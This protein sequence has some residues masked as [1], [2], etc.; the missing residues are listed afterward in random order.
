MSVESNLTFSGTVLNTTYLEV[1]HNLG[2]AGSSAFIKQIIGYADS[3]ITPAAL[4]FYKARGNE[5]S[6]ATVAANDFLGTQRYLGYDGNSYELSSAIRG[7]VD[8]SVS[9]GN[10]PGM[11]NF[12]TAPSGTLQSRMVIDSGGSVGIGTW[13]T[14]SKPHN[15]LSVDGTIGLEE[16]ASADTDAATYGQLWVKS[17]DPNELMFTDGDGKDIA[18]SNQVRYVS[19]NYSN[20]MSSV[21]SWYAGYFLNMGTSISASDWT[22]FHSYLSSIMVAT[23]PCQVKQITISCSA[24][25]TEPYEIE[26]WDVTIPADGASAPSTAAKIGDTIQVNSG[27]DMTVNRLYNVVHPCNHD[28]AAG[29]SMHIATRYTD[30]SGTKNFYYWLT[31]EIVETS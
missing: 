25:S 30:G 14:T 11:L 1:G 17:T 23:T 24:S 9:N 13:S 5:G 28:L 18:I 15:T 19:H 16:R 26:I 10:V 4:D 20:R 29:H 6:P 2:T 8:G 12:L 31:A 3:A 27:S 22:N 21:N 7:D